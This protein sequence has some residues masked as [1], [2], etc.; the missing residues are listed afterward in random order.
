MTDTNDTKKIEAIDCKDVVRRL[1]EFIDNELDELT[2]DQIEHHLN[3]CRSCL[4]RHEFE[5]TLKKR[6]QNAGH[7]KMPKKTASR[8]QGLIDKF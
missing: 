6:V 1:Y 3:D 2:H 7:E 8:L 4:S 5:T